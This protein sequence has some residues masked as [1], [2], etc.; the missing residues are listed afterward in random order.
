[1]FDVHCPGCGT[2]VLLTTRRILALE[3]TD[4]GILVTYRC[5]AGHEGLH[6]TGRAAATGRRATAPADAA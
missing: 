3:N 2:R 1:M 6:V 4:T 5:W